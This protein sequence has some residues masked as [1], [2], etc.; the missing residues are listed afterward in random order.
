MATLSQVA[1]APAYGSTL[2]HTGR[3]ANLHLK[4]LHY[5]ALLAITGD[6]LSG[7]GI[8]PHTVS[9]TAAEKNISGIIKAQTKQLMI[10]GH[11]VRSETNVGAMIATGSPESKRVKD[12]LGLICKWEQ[13]I[14]DCAV[15][16]AELAARTAILQDLSLIHI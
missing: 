8:T 3:H 2:V 7:S 12:H 1:T 10:A 5:E 4:G 9:T 6:G 16:G 13:W 15:T 14:A 11:A